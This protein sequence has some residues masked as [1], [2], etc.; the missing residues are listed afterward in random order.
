VKKSRVWNAF[1]PI[2]SAATVDEVEPVTADWLAA[3]GCTEGALRVLRAIRQDVVPL[4]RS[5][6]SGQRRRQMLSSFSF[7]VH[8]RT[9][10]VPCPAEDPHSYIHLR[11]NYANVITETKLRGQLPSKWCY[12]TPVDPTDT[13]RRV[14]RMLDAQCEWFARFVDYDPRLSDIELLQAIRQHLHYFANMAQMR[15]Q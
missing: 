1:L 7:L 13:E 15:V 9:S 11:L 6:Q 8:D 2:G 5:L 10:G 14:H 3:R 4:V 12:L